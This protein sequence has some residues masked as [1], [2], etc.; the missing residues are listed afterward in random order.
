MGRRPT[1]AGT[2]MQSRV[3]ALLDAGEPYSSIRKATGLSESSIS[4][5]NLSRKSQI[6]RAFDGEPNAVNLVSRM[7]EAADSARSARLAAVRLGSPVGIAR[8][9][10]LEADILGKLLGELGVNDATQREVNAQ[11]M[12]IIDALGTL[13][14]TDPETARAF[15]DHLSQVPELGDLTKSLYTRIGTR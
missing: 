7:L 14:D 2:S 5:F 15:A 4:R 13:A 9:T 3:E 8:A 11:I 1:I 10:K 12:D 6:S